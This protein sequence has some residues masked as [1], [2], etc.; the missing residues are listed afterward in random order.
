[1]KGD[2]KEAFSYMCD[3]KLFKFQ[4]QILRPWLEK[5]CLGPAFVSMSPLSIIYLSKLHAIRK[6]VTCNM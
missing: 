2:N 1:M 3:D 4:W 5:E 6:Y